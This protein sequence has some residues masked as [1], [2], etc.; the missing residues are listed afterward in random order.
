MNHLWMSIPN[1]CLWL[2]VGRPFSWTA[3]TNDQQFVLFLKAFTTFVTITPIFSS[4]P[5]WWKCVS[6]RQTSNWIFQGCYLKL[7]NGLSALAQRKMKLH[8]KWNDYSDLSP[9]KMY[10]VNSFVCVWDFWDEKCS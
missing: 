8:C 1:Q 4:H 3:K 9:T 5:N 2:S 7:L 6:S 10:D